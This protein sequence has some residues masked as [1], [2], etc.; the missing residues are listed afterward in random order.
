MRS[1]ELIRVGEKLLNRQKI[2]RSIDRILEL[3]ARGLSQQQAA[4]EL[5]IDRTFISRLET[6]GE[7]RKG[8]SIAL[9]GFPLSNKEEIAEVAVAEGLEFV[10]VMNND[11]RW[12][13]VRDQSGSDL[14]AQV[15]DVIAEV[16]RHDMV[17]LIGSRERNSAA[18]ALVDGE[19]YA[20][21]LGRS[22][23]TEDRHVDPERLREIIRM[24]RRTAGRRVME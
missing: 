4:A 8:R 24:L 14:L 7:V 16:R 5:G 19:V 2:D 22:P 1:P 20:I 18:A 21:E 6:L 9:I 10:L 23:I 15:M 12:H 13:F 3:R 11:E 17:I